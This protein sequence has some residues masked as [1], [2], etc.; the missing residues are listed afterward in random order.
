LSCRFVLCLAST[1][2]IVGC[3]SPK[4]GRLEGDVRSLASG[5]ED[6]RGTLMR[7][8]TQMQSV[9]AKLN[10]DSSEVARRLNS[11][12]TSNATL[13][14]ENVFLRR[15]IERIVN[16]TDRF[17]ALLDSKGKFSGVADKSS[18]DCNVR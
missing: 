3:E 11:L 4:M 12:E 10:N 18:K 16:K 1:L 9:T 8:Q 13:R 17:C 7:V 2:L 15:E 14:Q 6:Q 5:Q